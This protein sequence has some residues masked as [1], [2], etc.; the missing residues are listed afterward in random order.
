[1]EICKAIK[2]LAIKYKN[3]ILYIPFINPN[4]QKPVFKVLKGIDNVHL[5]RPQNIGSL[6]FS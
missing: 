1:M 4:V 3:F 2:S 6:Y 5:I